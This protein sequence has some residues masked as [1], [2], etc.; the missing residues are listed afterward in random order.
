MSPDNVQIA[1]PDTEQR[2]AEAV[3]RE[4]DKLYQRQYRSWR[5]RL[6][7]ATKELERLCA[8][9]CERRKLRELRFTSRA[10]EWSE[11]LPKV[12]DGRAEPW[13]RCSDLIGVRAIVLVPPDADEVY[14]AL[15]ERVRSETTEQRR[16]AHPRGPMTGYHAW[17]VQLEIP[18]EIEVPDETR[19]V[20]AELQIVTALRNVWGMISHKDFYKPDAGVPAALT[21]RMLRLSAVLDLVDDEIRE[22]NA[23]VAMATAAIQERVDHAP[24]AELALIPLDEASLIAAAGSKLTPEFKDLRQLARDS[25]FVV[26]GFAQLVK[27]GFEAQRFL[28]LCEH[29]GITTLEDV[30]KL[31]HRALRDGYGPILTELAAIVNRG[32]VDNPEGVLFDRPLNVLQAVIMLERGYAALPSPFKSRVTQAIYG[33]RGRDEQSEPD[34]E[35]ES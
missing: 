11:V 33:L 16:W 10:K 25:Q 18:D 4:R 22:L 15:R 30:K 8:A 19:E 24:D 26:S 5:K 34:K 17:H 21:D 1:A 12:Q 3:L 35:T 20:G 32:P 13:S 14:A 9:D 29:V 2:A 28:A 31:C 7:A 23:S 27:P 6:K